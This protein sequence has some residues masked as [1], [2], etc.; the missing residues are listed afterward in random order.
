MFYKEQKQKHKKTPPKCEKCEK[1]RQGNIKEGIW[2][3]WAIE[4]EG[5]GITSSCKCIVYGAL[6]KELYT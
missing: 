3:H 2:S 4:E 5:D 6:L 1:R